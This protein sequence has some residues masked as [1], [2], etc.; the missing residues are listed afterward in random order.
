MNYLLLGRPNVGKSSIFNILTGKKT[1]IIHKE[2]GTTRDWHKEK[3]CFTNNHY[4]YDTPGIVI[5]SKDQEEK[6]TKNI[7]E[8]LISKT[9]VLLL[10]I[11]F[12]LKLN[13]QDQLIVNWLRIFNKEIVLLINKKDK[14]KKQINDHFRFGIKDMF[15][16]SCAHKVGFE[17][18]I[19]Y[20]DNKVPSESEKIK[21]VKSKFDYSIAIF[22][23]PNA[24]KST[25]L[26]TL[27]G[28]ERSVTSAKFGTT[29]DYVIEDFKY[30]TSIIRIIDTA[31]IGRKSKINNKS[32][33]YYAVQKTLNKISNINSA[34]MIIDSIKGLDRQDK[35]IINLVAN[36]SKSLI[37]VFN[38]ID[39]IGNII[40]FKKDKLLELESTVH[41]L[42]NIKIFFIS[43]FLR[44]Q[45]IKILE[46]TYTNILLKKNNFNTS[47]LNKWLK[48]CTQMKTHPMI[49]KKKVNFKYAVKIKDN[50]ITI[51][52][53]CNYSDKIKKNYNQYLTNNFNA[54]FKILNQKTK[55][56]F[57]KSLKSLQ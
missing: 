19:E 18:L 47:L 3:I 11:D 6:K 12:Q 23:K 55:I 17:K 46:Y 20:L 56:V 51:K 37:I 39:L 28:Y 33:N 44:K 36:N 14:F 2:E 57:S 53:F 29:S 21:Y 42:K 5:H 1:N 38:K 8:N 4:I 26:N 50:P 49:E 45:I 30:K 35:R 54:Y 7:L 10:V 24:G 34:I 25:F 9:N 32:I 52:I 16:L 22:G 43:S 41:Q 15:F 13:H 48:Q 31:G 40:K 27:L